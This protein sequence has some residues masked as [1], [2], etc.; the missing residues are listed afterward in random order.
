MDQ[1]NIQMDLRVEKLNIIQKLL[2]VDDELLLQT[3]KNMLEVG[4]RQKNAKEELEEKDFW[5]ELTPEQQAKIEISI[6]QLDDGQGI[7][8]EE[9]MASFRKKYQ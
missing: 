2:I 9:V 8:H 7:P 4:L 6:K 1:I 5:D 3:I